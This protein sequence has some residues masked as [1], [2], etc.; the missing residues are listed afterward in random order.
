MT[1]ILFSGHPRLHVS[2]KRQEN[3]WQNECHKTTRITTRPLLL[4]KRDPRSPF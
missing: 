2:K 3:E 1:A 4:L